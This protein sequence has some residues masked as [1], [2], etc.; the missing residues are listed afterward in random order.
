[1][2][3]WI[4][5][6]LLTCSIAIIAVV[7]YYG[8][9][10]YH[11]SKQTMSVP[12]VGPSDAAASSSSADQG[13][14]EELSL[15][16]KWDG[17]ETVHILLLGADSRGDKEMGRSDSIMVASINPVTKKAYLMSIMRDTY[18]KIPGHGS[19]R[20][21]AAFSYGG[22]DLAMRTVGDLLGININYYI[23]TDFNGF[24]SLVDAIGGIDLYVEKDMK[25]SDGGDKHRYDIDLK[26]GE[27]HLDGTTAL[28]YVRFRHDA[29]SDFTRTERQ[30]KF[31]VAVAA[32]IQSTSSIFKLPG[33]LSAVSPYIKTNLSLQDLIKLAGL[34]FDIS[35]NEVVKV[36]IPPNQLLQNEK[37]GGAAV[38]K[39]DPPALRQYVEQVLAN[40]VQ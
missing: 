10:L 33:I 7:G 39:T 11:F 40:K 25:Y 32:K 23:Y 18:A 24:I 13:E 1:M 8:Y 34:G 37:V 35:P 3:K 12:S 29:T 17:K 26:Q 22:S 5:W 36:Q 21:N 16:P 9:S 6:V 15:P 38:L 27:Q 4:K 20:V 28:Q 30:R 14:P 2:R 19:S 31:L